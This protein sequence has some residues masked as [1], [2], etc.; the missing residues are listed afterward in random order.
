M[1]NA[2]PRIVSVQVGR[3]APLGPNGV[4]SGFIKSAVQG[5]IRVGPLGLQGDE[6]ADLSVHGG[7]DKA[8]YIYPSEHYP[9]WSQD[10]P[11]HAS[12]LVP[13]AFGENITTVGIDED[14]VSVGEIFRIGTAE[15]QVTQPRMPCFK[16]ALRFDDPTLGRIMVQS[17]RT[18]WYMRV[19]TPG[20]IQAGDAMES[21]RRPNPLW[22]I[23]RFN[24]FIPTRGQ[25]VREFAELG[26]LEGIPAVWKQAAEEALG[27]ATGAP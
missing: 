18:G 20:T 15:L 21:V 7:P 11:R 2:G 8:V 13:G 3:I 1:R 26:A 12:V 4:P 17:G 6:Q 22:T 16:L 10:A 9:R 5:P 14:A 23:A 24:R 25:S 19:R 27:G